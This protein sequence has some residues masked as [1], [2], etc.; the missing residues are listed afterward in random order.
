MS[1]ENQAPGINHKGFLRLKDVC[2]LIGL[3]KTTVWELSKRDPEFPKPVKLTSQC[4][5][6]RADELDA[7]IESRERVQFKGGAHV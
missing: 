4:T 1:N 2:Q 3:S 6:W 7:W 5:A